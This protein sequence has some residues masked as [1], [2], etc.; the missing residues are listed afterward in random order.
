[1]SGAAGGS[2]A[3]VAE[4]ERW[5]R[6]FVDTGRLPSALP[7]VQGRLVRAVHRGCLPS[8]EV[9]VKVL[10]FPRAK[11]RLRYALRGLPAAHEARM[12]AA[13]AAAGIPCP[14]VVAARTARRRGLPFRSML[15]LRALPHV[16]ESR[17]AAARLADEA[18]LAARLL[19]AGVVHPDL[20]GGNFLRL[21][22]G[23]LAVLDLQSARF[24][25]RG[26]ATRRRIGVAVRLVQERERLPHAMIGAA[27]LQSG[28][29][30]S[31]AEVARVMVAAVRAR[32]D[33][34]RTR[35]RRCLGESTE[36]T[37][38][39][40]W[41]GIEHRAR[42]ELGR[43]DWRCGGRELRRA[44]LGQRALQLLEGRA[45]LFPAFRQ[46]WWWF[47]GGGALYAPA[48]CSEERIESGVRDAIA[49]YER[50]L[51]GVEQRGGRTPP[52][53]EEHGGPRP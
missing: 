36:F 23:R 52:E 43:G 48:E 7:L 42:G 19:A 45:P 46:N 31:E 50:L 41:R 32:G 25:R 35:I 53:K 4:I 49:A 47:G 1:M 21:P 16:Q 29:L 40:G 8:G 39:I 27:L 9:F 2:D 37:R 28:L 15:V 14:A 38:C 5:W 44:W 22:D 26:A 12:L 17:D 34:L 3:D 33:F 24:V 30:R 13:T 6:T 11:D 10:A 20:H 51:R 18:R